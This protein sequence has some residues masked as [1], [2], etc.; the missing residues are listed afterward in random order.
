MFGICNDRRAHCAGEYSNCEAAPESLGFEDLGFFQPIPLS[1]L[2]LNFTASSSNPFPPSLF[3]EG[4]S[5]LKTLDAQYGGGMSVNG[6]L[7]V[8]DSGTAAGGAFNAILV[9][10]AASSQAIGQ[11]Y[12]VSITGSQNGSDNPFC[13][14]TAPASASAGSL[15]KVN[16]GANGGAC[17][18]D[19]LSF[20]TQFVALAATAVTA[21]DDLVICKANKLSGLLPT[22]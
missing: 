8:R 21:I 9:F 14:Q 2:G 15:L 17:V 10:V 7:S 11:S 20:T 16:L 4:S 19:D 6:S 3:V 13:Q 22:G 12:P 1:Y 18:A 5:G